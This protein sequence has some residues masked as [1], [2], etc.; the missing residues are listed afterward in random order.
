MFSRVRAMTYQSVFVLMVLVWSFC[1]AYPW[2]IRWPFARIA[3]H[4]PWLLVL[5]QIL[6]EQRMPAGMNIRVDLLLIVPAIALSFVIY[7]CRLFMFSRMSRARQNS[8]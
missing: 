8:E 7:V 4:A 3:I 2:D 6:Y 5:L 1:L